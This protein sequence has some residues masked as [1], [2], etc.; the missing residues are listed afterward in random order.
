MKNWKVGQRVRCDRPGKQLPDCFVRS[1]D[2]DSVV[3]FCPS[4]NT[5]ICGRRSNLERLGWKLDDYQTDLNELDPDF[6][7]EKV[8][9]NRNEN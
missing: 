8:Y 4:M 9:L 1:V 6:R 7:V 3:I 5:V 2:S